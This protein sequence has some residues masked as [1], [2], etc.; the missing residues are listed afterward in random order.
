MSGPD[1]AAAAAR[2]ASAIPAPV[3]AVLD[4]LR[5][6]G[7]AAWVVGGSLRDALFERAPRDWDL[8]TDAL[9]PRVVE[10]FPGAVYE[11]RFGTVAV[12]RDGELFEITTFRTE[13]DYA[14][15]RRPHR[16]EFGDDLE[17]DLA[18]RDFTVNAM[19]WGG[20]AGDADAGRTPPEP[21]S[22]RSAASTTW[23]DAGCA[24]SATRPSG[25]GRTRCGWF[26]RS[27]SPP[28]TTSR[29]RSGRS[30]RSP[31]TPGSS[32]TSRG[33]ASGRSS[34]GCW[35]RRRRRPGSGSRW[36]P[37]CSR[38]SRPSSRR[39]GASPRTRRPARTCGTTRCEPSTR[40]PSVAR[41]CAWRRCCTT[42]ASRSRSPTADSTTT[43]SRGPRIA[44]TLL[45][46]LRFARTTTDDVAHL[47]AHHMFT[48]EADP[49]DVA[50]RRF[51]RRIGPGQ[52]DALF[53]LR[54]ADDI[55]SGLSPD[56]PATA[57]FRARVEAELAAEPPLD[58]HALAIDG[59][60]LIR[61][62]GL[63][64]GPSLGRVLDAL[65]DRVIG[66]PA[67]NDRATLML[68]AQG[69]LADMP[70]AEVPG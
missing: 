21:W 29:S 69:M 67:L 62:L 63:E 35:R 49:S 44:E 10:L 58:R 41:S 34:S 18:R 59:D 16:V 54:R 28:P 2:L 66:D 3:V 33:S 64:P 27:G 43:T 51:I 15:H 32:S 17:A 60:D 14:D 23:A 11:N 19:A 39:S 65:L 13:H 30:R 50:V 20:P 40:R 52:L 61:E 1:A 37:A 26:A 8:A 57:A 5:D 47:V 38:R 4:H 56:D 31:P 42:S 6:N 55:G 22:T 36:T 48:V 46:R 53:E 68:L 45:R 9:P 7:H 25:S 12:R 70:R 24:P